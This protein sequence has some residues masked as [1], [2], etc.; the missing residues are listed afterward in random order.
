MSPEKLKVAV[1]V[2]VQTTKVVLIIQF[3]VTNNDRKEI[4]SEKNVPI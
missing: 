2:N 3:M 1:K 4:F